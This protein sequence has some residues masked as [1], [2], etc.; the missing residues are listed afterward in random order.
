M[1]APSVLVRTSPVNPSC[2]KRWGWGVPRRRGPTGVNRAVQRSWLFG[3]RGTFTSTHPEG[4]R[5]SSRRGAP[6]S[7]G[8]SPDSGPVARADGH[9]C[10]ASWPG[11]PWSGQEAWGLVSTGPS[12]LVSAGLGEARAGEEGSAESGGLGVCASAREPLWGRLGRASG[13]R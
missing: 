5:Q 6:P 1:F 11:P 12:S 9:P 2:C 7:R 3:L 4:L 10:Y 13:G 8:P